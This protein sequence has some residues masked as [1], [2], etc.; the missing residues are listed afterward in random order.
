MSWT[1]QPRLCR[2]RCS[3]SGYSA[4]GL[5]VVPGWKC[6][7]IPLCHRLGELCRSSSSLCLSPSSFLADLMDN[8]ELIRNVTLCGHLHHGKVRDCSASL[9]TG[10][11]FEPAHLLS[12][13]SH[14]DS[15]L[16][17]WGWV[18]GWE[19]KTTLL[20]ALMELLWNP[21]IYEL[22]SWATYI[23]EQSVYI[24]TEKVKLSLSLIFIT[25]YFLREVFPRK[26]S[27]FIEK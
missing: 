16:K 23:P 9:G 19:D 22:C 12:P 6:L 17:S 21:S 15:S 1:L 3:V 14:R 4:A 13:Y 24:W 20:H 26:I 25:F 2:S 11:F 7:K 5:T 10:F 18:G 8:S 27:S